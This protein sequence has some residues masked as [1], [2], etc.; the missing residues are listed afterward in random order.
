MK[1]FADASFFHKSQ[2]GIEKLLLIHHNGTQNT[3]SFQGFSTKM[4]A[5][6]F[7]IFFLLFQKVYHTTLK[8]HC[9]SMKTSSVCKS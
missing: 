7:M 9:E 6:N 4:I 8:R 5:L 1:K 2:K 3:I